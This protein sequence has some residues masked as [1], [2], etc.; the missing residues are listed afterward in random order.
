LELEGKVLS[1]F[2]IEELEDMHRKRAIDKAL[3]FLRSLV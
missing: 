3:P 1:E 2:A